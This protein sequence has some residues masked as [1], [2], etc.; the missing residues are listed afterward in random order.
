M[1]PANKIKVQVTH[2]TCISLYVI[3]VHVKL[4]VH[5]VHVILSQCFMFAFTVILTYCS[6]QH[7]C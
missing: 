3:R 2:Y 4:L 6:A 7:A 1:L 5:D